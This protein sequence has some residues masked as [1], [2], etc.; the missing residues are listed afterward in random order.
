MSSYFTSDVHLRLDRP[1][2]DQRFASW[3][4]SLGNDDS[5]TI[6]GD[7]CDFW[8]A[9]RQYQTGLKSCQGLRALADF[10]IRGG[11]LTIMPGNHDGWLGPFYE[12]EVGAR[13]A[14]EP[15]EVEAFGLRIHLRHGHT[16]GG[17]PVWK[18]WMESRSFLTAFRSLPSQLATT[19][20][21]RLERRNE[22]NRELDDMRQ[23]AAY[24]RYVDSCA[25]RADLVLIGH[26]HRSFEDAGSAP[27]LMI[28][29]GW[30]GQSSFVKVDSSG[31][32]LVVEPAPSSLT[33]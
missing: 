12:N 3:V 13:F 10:R 11:Q 20:D 19:F 33:C 14:P 8:F 21:H 6:V 7:L 18:G 25:G 4:E 31:A 1:E 27:R 17:H 32:A 28:P 16:L 26:I 22:K 5:L 2:R 24:R 23:L 9:A 29:G 15:L 30:F